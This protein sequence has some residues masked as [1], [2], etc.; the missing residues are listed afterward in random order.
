[1]PHSNWGFEKL[2]EGQ[3]SK[4]VEVHKPFAIRTFAKNIKSFI[5]FYSQ[6]FL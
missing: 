4:K 2:L 1:M 6:C 3:V 5:D